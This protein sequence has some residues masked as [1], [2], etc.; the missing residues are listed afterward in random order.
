[1]VL[2]CVVVFLLPRTKIGQHLVSS[3]LDLLPGAGRDAD[4]EMSGDR[5]MHSIAAAA[6]L[7]PTTILQPPSSSSPSPP[8]PPPPL[9][10]RRLPHAAS[11]QVD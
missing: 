2:A 11:R 4:R 8:P 7:M 9:G 6:L 3:V 10:L 1:M 5:A